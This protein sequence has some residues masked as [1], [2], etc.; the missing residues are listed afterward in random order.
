M[1]IFESNPETKALGVM[2][3][4]DPA[5]YDDQVKLRTKMQ[6][7]LY[8]KVADHEGPLLEFLDCYTFD[9]K[10]GAV[11]HQ[12]TFD[13]MIRKQ[14]RK[15]RIGKLQQLD[16][17]YIIALERNDTSTIAEI[18]Q[19]KTQL[20]DV[21]KQEIPKYEPMNGPLREYM[22]SLKGYLPEILI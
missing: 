3:L 18:V 20:R 15:V 8:K 13:E 2:F 1:I 19:K 17:Q 22:L 10:T 9:E 5:E 4:M 14:W 11:F 16:T 12:D 6:G 21:T 7:R